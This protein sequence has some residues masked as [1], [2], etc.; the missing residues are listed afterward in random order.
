MVQP[1][2]A[3][4]TLGL[5][6]VLADE[7]TALRAGRVKAGRGGVHFEGDRALGYGACL[8]LRSAIRVQEEV[9]VGEVTSDDE[10][11]RFV[12][13]IDWTRLVT[14]DQTLAVDASLR[15]SPLTHSVFAAQRVKDG[16][17]DWWRERT[18][19]RPSVNRK[20][21]DV[22]L[23][24]V[25]NGK[26]ARLYRDLAGPSLHKRGYRP[27]QVRSPLNEALAAGILLLSAWDRASPL[28]DPMCGSGTFVIEAAHL[29]T[30]R[31]PG[32][33]R[34]FPF[35][36]W[37]DF[38]QRA[39]DLMLADARRRVKR[40]L[41]FP[42][43]GADRHEGALSIAQRSARTAGVMELIELAH[44]PIRDLIPRVRPKT[45]VVNPPYGMRIGEGED[46]VDSWRDLG[47]FLRARCPGAQAFVLCGEPELT[48]HLGLRATWRHPV[49][50]GP[51]DCRLLRY[52][53]HDGG[54]SS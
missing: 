53:I 15:D 52:D 10:L 25:V 6:A 20:E 30:D 1:Y 8:W 37:P 13:S 24:L 42:I 12:R 18:D 17:A 32:I 35:F 28:L 22:P 44:S 50:N 9:G 4:C 29:A 27:A 23:K 19:R 39:W 31:A 40:T 33:D 21:P 48:R 49:H 16:V 2:F 3:A 34:R 45:V 14:P 11:Y 54:K 38:H 41:S 5:E 47:A 26:V 51:I 36:R 46:L 43:L 7:L